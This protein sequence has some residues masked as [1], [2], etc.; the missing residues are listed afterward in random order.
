MLMCTNIILSDERRAV[1]LSL[2]PV[3]IQ[4]VDIA[5]ARKEGKTIKRRMKRRQKKEA[6]AVRLL[7]LGSS[8]IKFFTKTFFCIFSSPPYSKNK[9]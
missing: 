5:Q 7:Y 9:K 2:P 3:K 1:R 6:K 4:T 8:P